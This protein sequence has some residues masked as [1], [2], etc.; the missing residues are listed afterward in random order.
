MA[1]GSGNPLYDAYAAERF[2]AQTQRGPG[3]EH[4]RLHP[5]LVDLTQGEANTLRIINS[6]YNRNARPFGSE[7][8]ANIRSRDF[9]PAQMENIHSLEGLGFVR[10]ESD[11]RIVPSF[12][13]QEH[14]R[15]PQPERIQRQS[16]RKAPK[17]MRG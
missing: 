1:G 5:G 13:F 2:R 15:R 6:R 11:G 16:R 4:R 12:V 10:I 14:L 3:T 8:Y 7:L 17:R 9:T